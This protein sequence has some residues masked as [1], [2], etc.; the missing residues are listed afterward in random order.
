MRIVNISKSFGD[1]LVLKDISLDIPQGDTVLI[2]G[3][4]GRGKTTLLRIIMGLEKPDSGTI[5]DAP[6]S[7]AAVF[8][9]DR[10]PL[11]FSA[12]KCVSYALPGSLRKEEIL[13][14]FSDLGL[15]G[16]ERKKA[17]ELSGGMRRRL[18]ILRAV[19]CPSEALLLDEPF[20]GLD[21]ETK[22][23]AAQYILKH[24]NGRTIIAVSHAEEDAALLNAREITI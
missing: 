23:K 12:Y 18:S 9:E 8:Q 22:K 2:S 1:K 5:T 6:E 20:T 13:S 21:P 10:L 11:D 14:G 17:G 19:L 7:F 4:S 3:V 15:T 24:K 16:E